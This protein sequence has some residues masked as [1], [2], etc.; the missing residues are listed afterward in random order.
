M[1]ESTSIALSYVLLGP[2]MAIA[3]PVASMV[4]AV[5]AVADDLRHLCRALRNPKRLARRSESGRRG[6]KICRHALPRDGTSVGGRWRFPTKGTRMI[7]PIRSLV[8]AAAFAIALV[9]LTP[10]GAG[11]G[12]HEAGENPCAAKAANP[13]AAKQAANPCAAKTAPPAKPANPCAG[14]EAAGSPSKGY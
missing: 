13:C 3:R 8:T 11:A 10:L 12:H 14:S 2:F 5:T 9:G 4:S 1:E 7:H 6:S